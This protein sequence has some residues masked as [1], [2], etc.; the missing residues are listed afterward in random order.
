MQASQESC[1]GRNW[2][3]VDVSSQFDQDHNFNY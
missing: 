2:T 3:D 1:E